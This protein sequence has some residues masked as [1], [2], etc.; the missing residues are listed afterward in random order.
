MQNVTNDI[1]DRLILSANAIEWSSM[2]NR[3]KIQC[4]NMIVDGLNLFIL[5]LHIILHFN[6]NI[7]VMYMKILVVL[8]R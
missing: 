1:L 5:H 3:E 6:L 8:F 4:Y 7:L 2:H